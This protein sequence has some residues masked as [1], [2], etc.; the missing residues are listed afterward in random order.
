MSLFEGSNHTNVALHAQLNLV[1]ALTVLPFLQEYF[2][3]PV[4]AADGRAYERYAIEQW[5][6]EHDTSPMTNE[7]MPHKQLDP[8]PEL[9]KRTIVLLA[10]LTDLTGE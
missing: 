2:E 7:P 3:D 9:L 8:D 1:V 4:R 10:K 6:K 5:L